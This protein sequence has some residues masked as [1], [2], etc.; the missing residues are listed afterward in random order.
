VKSKSPCKAVKSNTVLNTDRNI[1]FPEMKQN[2]N[3]I[4]YIVPS[5][6]RGQEEGTR[7]TR[8][9]RKKNLSPALK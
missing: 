4:V 8:R 7:R 3:E 1:N 9:T 5:E 2:F 6:G